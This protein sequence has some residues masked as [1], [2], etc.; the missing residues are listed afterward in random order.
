MTDFGTIT[1]LPGIDPRLLSLAEKPLDSHMG[2]M[3]TDTPAEGHPVVLSVAEVHMPRLPQEPS[4]R[5][6]G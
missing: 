1:R 3:L 4:W 5:G 2:N 6:E